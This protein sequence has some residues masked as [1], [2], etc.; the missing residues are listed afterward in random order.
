M[1][2]IQKILIVLFGV[3][4][5]LASCSDEKNPAQ[6]YGNTLVQSLKSA[7]SVENKANVEEVRK[8]IQ[9]FYAANGRYPADLS[10]LTAF[11]GMTLKSDK[12]DYN[13][14]AGTLTEKQ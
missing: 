12:Y 10:E 13:P 7:K 8:S 2:R 3:T 14:A 5:G 4:F 1:K 6:Q 9:E 11:N